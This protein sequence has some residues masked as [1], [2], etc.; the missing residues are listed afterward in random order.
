MLLI[1]FHIQRAEII[2]LHHSVYFSAVRDQTSGLK[3]TQQ[4]LQPL[5][6]IFILTSPHQFKN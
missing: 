4:A 5:S 2:G 3:H 1:L 6:H